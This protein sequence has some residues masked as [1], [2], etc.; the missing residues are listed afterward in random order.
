MSPLSTFR[1]LLAVDASSTTTQPSKKLEKTIAKSC[2]AIAIVA[3]GK[4]FTLG[5]ADVRQKFKS[6]A[7][8]A[9]L[10]S[11]AF[12]HGLATA[13]T[14]KRGSAKGTCLLNAPKS[15]VTATTLR[16]LN[17]ISRALNSPEVTRRSSAEVG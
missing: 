14:E 12:A 16:A 3:S 4:R 17:L 6:A 15:S 11:A 13:T 9:T 7:K 10:L 1:P 5:A 2:Q 8:Y